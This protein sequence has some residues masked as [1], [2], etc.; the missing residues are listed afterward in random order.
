MIVA[1]REMIY[2]EDNAQICSPGFDFITSLT[3]S[4][5]P[6]CCFDVPLFVTVNHGVMCDNPC[7]CSMPYLVHLPVDLFLLGE[8]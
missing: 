5:T 6:R 1:E 4:F 2:E 7:D 8:F 3:A